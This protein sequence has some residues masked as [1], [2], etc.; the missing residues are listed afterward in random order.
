MNERAKVA[1]KTD[2]VS[3]RERQF[4]HFRKR[5]DG[6]NIVNG[7]SMGVEADGERRNWDALSLRWCSGQYV[8]VCV[9]K[10]V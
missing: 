4:H 5:G 1:G 10:K 7:C 2:A 8:Y 6:G 9:E 3:K